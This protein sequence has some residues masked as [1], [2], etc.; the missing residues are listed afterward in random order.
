[1]TTGIQ[2][3]RKH[4]IKMSNSSKLH[5]AQQDNTVELEATS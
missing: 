1:M 2:E 4:T 3:T 5:R